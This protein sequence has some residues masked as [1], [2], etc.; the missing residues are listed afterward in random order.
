MVFKINKIS[1]LGSQCG[2]R[3]GVVYVKFIFLYG[4]SFSSFPNMPESHK[5]DLFFDELN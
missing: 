5:G 2:R 3:G 1:L 4:V